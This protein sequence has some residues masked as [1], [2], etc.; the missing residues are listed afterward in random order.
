MRASSQENPS[1]GRQILGWFN[2]MPVKRILAWFLA[3]R[4]GLIAIALASNAFIPGLYGPEWQRLEGKPL[5]DIWY[6]WDAGF[7]TAIS[8]FG[9]NFAVNL[10]PASDIAFMPLF[11]GLMRLVNPLIGCIDALCTSNRFLACTSQECAV[12]SG[13]LISNAALLLC[14]F[15]LFD[16]VRHQ[17]DQQTGMRSVWL[18][19][20]AP[21]S[22]FLSGVY[23]ESLFMLFVLVTFQALS[24][25]SFG[26]AVTAAAA[27][28]LTRE[29]GLALYPALIVYAWNQRGAS[30]ISQLVLA[31]MAPL[32][33]FAYVFGVGLLV[34]DGLAYFKV[35]AEIW[36]VSVGSH[37]FGS[38]GPYFPPYESKEY[39]SLWGAGPTWFNLGSTLF[40]LA[41]SI[42]AFRQNPSYGLFALVAI[43]VP[44]VGGTLASMPRFGGIIAPFYSV[45]GEWANSRWR[46]I[47]LYMACVAAAVF[48]AARFVTWRWIA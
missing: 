18:L 28:S 33:F 13:V 25:H 14:C 2:A 24:R 19:L 12:I 8:T 17:F 21:N 36:G 11:P 42:P 39:I 22:I 38:F 7:Y 32:T 4:V 41:L 23:T 35:N 15:L 45:G 43:L 31:Q 40:Y 30:R 16:L 9:Y 3:T 5:L 6:R 44:I 20:L 48:F 10:K 26:L 1:P 37:I 34:G 29:V 27:A 46:Q 47:A